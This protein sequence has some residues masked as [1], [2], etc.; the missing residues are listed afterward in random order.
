MVD[1]M[2]RRMGRR[3]A[4]ET[5]YP[6]MASAGQWRRRGS[7]GVAIFWANSGPIL[8]GSA[9][10]VWHNHLQIYPSAGT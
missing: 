9:V 10:V 3:T 2:M 5:G 7:V 8:C 4:I 6:M 1:P